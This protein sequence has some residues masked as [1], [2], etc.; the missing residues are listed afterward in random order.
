MTDKD[1]V[2]FLNRFIFI[3]VVQIDGDGISIFC[4]IG[5]S[6]SDVL[7]DLFTFGVRE[8]RKQLKILS[9]RI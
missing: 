5:L 4:A 2:I 1:D 8:K 3:G 6:W 9:R 7:R